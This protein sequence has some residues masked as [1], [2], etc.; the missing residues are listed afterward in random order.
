MPKEAMFPMHAGG[1]EGLYREFA[2]EA[3]RRKLKTKVLCA[4]IK[5]DVFFYKKGRMD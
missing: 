2:A 3:E 5:G 4:G 1:K